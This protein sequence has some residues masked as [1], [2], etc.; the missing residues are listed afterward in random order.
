MRRR[1]AAALVFIFLGATL[2]PAFI[3]Q[4][5]ADFSRPVDVISITWPH[6]PALTTSV[7]TARKEVQS[8][9]IPYW[10]SHASIE[11]TK[12]LD[13]SAPVSMSVEV[14]C[15]GD[16]TVTY[17]N[18]VANKFYASQGL[19]SNNRYLVIL[20]PKISKNCVWA[21]KSIVGDY[22]ISFG[23]SIF[24]DNAQPFV[25]THELGHALGL[26]HTNY[27]SCPTPGDSDWT[28]CQNLEYAGA[29]DLMSNIDTSAPLNLYH[30]WRLGRMDESSIQSILNS[31]TYTVNELS[32]GSGVRG[33]FIHDTEGFYWVEYRKAFGTFKAGLYIYR[34]DTPVAAASTSSPNPEY[35][36]RYIGDTSGDAWLLNL[37][38]YQY[39]A[40]PIGSPSGFHFAT[41]TGNVT[42]DMVEVGGQAVV[43]VNV[44]PGVILHQMPPTPPDLTKYTFA[45]TDFGSLYEVEPVV[46]GNALTDPTLQI[47]NGNFPSED[48]RVLRTQVSA[49]PIYQSKY[50]FISSE[51]VQYESAYWAAQALKEID[52]ATAKCPAKVAQIHPVS[53][54]P[55]AQ[56]SA[57]SLISVSTSNK[58][59]QNLLATFQVK[60]STMVGTYVVSN[61]D[62]SSVE[63]ARWLKITKKMGLR[64]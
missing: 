64:L 53:Y 56:V 49:N 29:V 9:T 27:M 54:A 1:S 32:S 21:A 7:S 41:H 33:L 2:T 11:F 30:M 51:A 37:G 61:Y 59:T 24:Q 58:K 5:H 19:N 36:G 12:G 42:L 31:G 43:N 44:K 45:T 55:P 23:I 34:T 4:A 38:D 3:Q 40:H 6:A 14:P 39:S 26:G 48:H 50:T 35:S 57:R 52:L 28:Q 47:C 60:G 8:Y 16:A 63:I 62:F 15:N 13:S 20:S 10:R 46:G 18:D 25:I 22:K 17:M